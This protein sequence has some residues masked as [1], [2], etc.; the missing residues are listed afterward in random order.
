MLIK[1]RNARCSLAA[2]LVIRASHTVWL[3]AF[4]QSR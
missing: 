1:F 4:P 2:V 3:T